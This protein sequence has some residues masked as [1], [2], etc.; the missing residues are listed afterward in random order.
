M[1]G[2]EK[3][4]AMRST[5]VN[6]TMSASRIRSRRPTGYGCL[7]GGTPAGPEGIDLGSACCKEPPV[8]AP[9]PKQPRVS[10]TVALCE[11]QHLAGESP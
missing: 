8:K 3:G 11:Q 2:T 5:I 7:C 1:T 9:A 4:R 10:E 6:V